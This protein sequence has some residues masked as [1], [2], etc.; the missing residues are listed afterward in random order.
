MMNLP[1]EGIVIVLFLGTFLGLSVT[2]LVA[3][4]LNP[5]QKTE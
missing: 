1:I 5:G 4:L 3:F 2:G